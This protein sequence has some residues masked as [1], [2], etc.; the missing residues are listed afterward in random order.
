MRC[1][2]FS[3]NLLRS[4]TFDSRFVELWQN[5]S[6]CDAFEILDSKND[7]LYKKWFKNW[8]SKTLIQKSENLFIKK[9]NKLF[10]EQLFQECA[11]KKQHWRFYG[12][13]WPDKC[14]FEREFSNKFW[15]SQNSFFIEIE[16]V[17]KIL[18]QFFM[19]C[20]YSSYTLARNN[21]F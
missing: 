11:K 12:V 10:T 17:V 8:F 15:F 20:G 2:F 13:Y 18:I 1:K 6:K 5:G 16:C 9:K 3:R 7:A 19:L 21:F 4:K 14:F